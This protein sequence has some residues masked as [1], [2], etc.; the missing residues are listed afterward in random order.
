[1]MP[2]D[3]VVCISKQST[4]NPSAEGCR[5]Q[6]DTVWEKTVSI[7]G[8]YSILGITVW[9]IH[10]HTTDSVQH[11]VRGM[12]LLFRATNN[13][14]GS[15]NGCSQIYQ[16][17]VLNWFSCS[18]LFTQCRCE[19]AWRDSRVCDAQWRIRRVWRMKM[20]SLTFYSGLTGQGHTDDHS[21][22]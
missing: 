6:T 10:E 4:V 13:V 18:D 7:R 8:H 11:T 2:G 17:W 20:L 12:F 3:F 1:M 22:T 19:F 21:Q 16:R 9:V 15:L 5:G 14:S